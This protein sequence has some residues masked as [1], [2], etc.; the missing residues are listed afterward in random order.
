M[1][2]VDCN[3][4]SRMMSGIKGKNSRP[5]LIL[6]RFLH[7]QGFRYRLHV[8]KLPGKPDIVLPRYELCIFVHGCF[9]HHHDGCKYAT[10]PKTRSAYWMRKFVA[11][12]QRDIQVKMQLH[13]AG[14]RVFEIWE[15]G[16]KGQYEREINW[17]PEYINSDIKTLNWP[18]YICSG[19]K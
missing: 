13:V 16:L 10:T 4:R 6:R 1:G 17:L 11:N 7:Q 15:C 2:I 18:D 14:W 19:D 9:W 8:E 12:R 3:T 5:E